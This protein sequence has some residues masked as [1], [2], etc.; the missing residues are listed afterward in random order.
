MIWGVHLVY[1]GIYLLAAGFVFGTPDLWVA[2]QAIVRG[3]LG[4]GDRTL[5][6]AGKA[7]LSGNMAW[8]ALVTFV[9]NFF[10]GSVVFITLPSC[11]IPASGTL[12]AAYRALLWGLLLAPA[13]LLQAHLML[14]HSG[15][16]LLEGEGYILATFFSLMLAVLVFRSDPDSSF[17]QRYGRGLLLNL[18]GS[19]LVALVLAVA[20]IYEAVEVILMLRSAG[21]A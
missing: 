1:F 16:L 7:Y 12:V 6:Y 2:I 20:A 8:A 13:T 17:L 19:L 3:A 9:I 18:K 5:E 10:L 21:G 14:A 11:V 4:G 15:T